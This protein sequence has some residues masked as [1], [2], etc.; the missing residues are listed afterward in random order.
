VKRSKKVFLSIAGLFLALMVWIGYDI[1]SR[2]T[3]PGSKKHMKESLLKSQD[4]IKSVKI[5]D[6][7]KDSLP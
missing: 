3:F 1:S 2:T 6:K 4:S 5:H 7:A